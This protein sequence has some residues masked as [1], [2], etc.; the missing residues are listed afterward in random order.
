MSVSGYYFTRIYENW[1]EGRVGGKVGLGI[2]L[3]PDFTVRT[4]FR[5]ER[6]DIYNPQPSGTT[7]PELVNALGSHDLYGFSV[8]ASHDTRDSPFLPTQ[9]HLL[10]VDFEEIVGSFQYPHVDVQAR[11]YY[12]LRQ[13]ADGSGRHV[14]SIGGEFGVTGDNTPIYDNFF[15]GGFSSLRGFAFRGAAPRDGDVIVG[16][17]YELLGTAEYM[18][19]ITADDAL[20][21]VVF[22]DFGD[23]EKTVRHRRQSIPRGTRLWLADQRAGDGPGPDR[24]RLCRAR[25]QCWRRSGPE[26][27]LLR[28][29]RPQ[30]LKSRRAP[31]QSRRVRTLVRSGTFS[32]RRLCC[33]RI[34]SLEHR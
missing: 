31:L 29:L 34:R 22:C 9:G 28:G 23:A 16:G 32:P 17:Q 15:P 8:G 26:L 11:Q 30:L 6:V 10:S 19:P 13:R 21:G 7:V 20:R 3:T 24:A 1:T 33:K 18:F 2:A 12:L 4:A 5:G 25:G 27:Q 14:F